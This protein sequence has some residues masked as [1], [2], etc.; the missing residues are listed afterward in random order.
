[1]RIGYIS[2]L[3]GDTN[4]N[5]YLSDTSYNYV[6]VYDGDTHE[7][8]PFAGRLENCYDCEFPTAVSTSISTP[9]GIVGSSVDDYVYFIDS[10]YC[11]VRRVNTVTGEINTEIG[12]LNDCRYNGDG[13]VASNATL[14]YPTAMW[15]DSTGDIYI[16]DGYNYRI[17]KV[18]YSNDPTA[19]VAAAEGVIST[20]AGNGGCCSTSPEYSKAL[21][22]YINS[23][24]GLWG[25]SSNHLYFIDQSNNRIRVINLENGEFMVL[26]EFVC[27]MNDYFV[28][29]LYP[30]HLGMISLAYLFCCSDP[31]PINRH[32][33]HCGWLQHGL[34]VQRRPAGLADGLHQRAVLADGR[35]GGQPAL[36]RLQQQTRPEAHGRLVL[37]PAV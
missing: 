7:L 35:Q 10:S 29:N 12:V 9:R 37:W 32:R 8:S 19:L 17:R 36:R 24:S 25:D 6:Y 21:E 14:Y 28:E 1:M 13:M 2:S 20:I 3:W 31:C 30:L 16:A 22:T 33:Q 11:V 23:V 27:S 26:L 15:M 18:T 34:R 5:L 4:G